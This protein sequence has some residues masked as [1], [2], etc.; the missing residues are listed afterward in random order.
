VFFRSNRA[1]GARIW[2]LGV[3]AAGIGSEPTAVTS[4]P[5]TETNPAVLAAG[6]TVLLMMRSDR[7][8]TLS[9]LA[10]S[11]QLALPQQAAVRRFAGSGTAVPADAVRNATA[12][13]FGELLDYTPNRPRGDDPAPTELYTPGTVAVYFTRGPADPS[14]G[15]GDPQRLRQLLT[16]YL[17]ANVRVVTITDQ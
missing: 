4:G 7:N 6:D 12:G 10:A 16:D 15:L 9:A 14:P 1:G 13:T 17:P 5:S 11:A 2:R 3:S 8:V